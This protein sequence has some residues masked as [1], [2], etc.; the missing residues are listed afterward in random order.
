MSI[1]VVIATIPGRQLLLKRAIDSVLSQTM[2]PDE[3]I[4]EVDN[5]R[6]GAP[7][8]RDKAINK[9]NNK[10]V[11]I[12]DDDD[13]LLPLHLELL[14]NTI[15][16]EQVDLV[17]PSWQN[18]NGPFT[19]LDHIL[20]KKWDN[21]DIHQVPITW[22]AKTSSLKDVGGFSGDFDVNNLILDEHGHRIGEDFNLIK[23]FVRYDK[24]IFHVNIKTWVW[25]CG[26]AGSTQGK[27]NG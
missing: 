16:K 8:T 13:Y 9:I 17:Y 6:V 2:L 15:E 3:I 14:F 5:E 25:N 21:N 20:G 7:I 1:S 27:P 26:H 22:M 12:L 23:N 19:H 11:A 18:E 4:I 10:Y 24:K